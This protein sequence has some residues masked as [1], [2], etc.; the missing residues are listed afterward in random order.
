MTVIFAHRGSKW[1]RP[2]NTIAAF[3]EALRVGSDGIELDVHRTKDNHLVVIH[4]ES[5]DRTTNGVGL[6]RDLT[7]A[8]LKELDAGSWFSVDYF[9]E[10]I[11]TFIEVLEFLEEKNFQG[12]L[13]I[14]IKTNKFHYPH[15]EREIAQVMQMRQWPF[16]YLYCSFSFNSL[17]IMHEEDPEIELAYL[18][19]R[20]PFKIFIGR[21]AKFIGALHPNKLWFFKRVTKVPFFGKNIR[22]WT[23]NKRKQISQTF[24]QKIVGFMTDNPELAVKI[25]NEKQRS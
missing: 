10:K 23:L 13:N 22:P 19:K 17:K 18:V 1:N 25:R 11:P 4:D 6:V 21:K 9:R 24:D 3:D 5:V 12:F 15:I 16:K 7:L 20:N 14:E 2:E 8:E